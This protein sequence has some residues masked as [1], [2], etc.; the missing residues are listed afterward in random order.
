[1]AVS[2]RAFIFSGLATAVASLVASPSAHAQTRKPDTVMAKSTTSAVF[3]ESA[4]T[5]KKDTR[6]PTDKAQEVSSARKVIGIGCL[7]GSDNKTTPKQVEDYFRQAFGNKGIPI[8][9]IC[10]V[11]PNHTGVSI[12]FF[13][14]GSLHVDS[15]TGIEGAF[16]SNAAI[17]QIPTLV[18]KF[19]EKFP[20]AVQMARGPG[21]NQE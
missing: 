21:L 13:I 8:E 3:S 9:F 20:E 17:A 6:T 10:E 14:N 2:R 12:D 1:M 5:P 11:I 15:T 7:L 18:E 4:D 19:K 16:G